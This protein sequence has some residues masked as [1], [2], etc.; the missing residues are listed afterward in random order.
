MLIFYSLRWKQL[1][2]TQNNSLQFNKEKP[3][4]QNYVKI[5]TKR[6]GGTEVFR[7]QVAQSGVT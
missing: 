5:L 7:P 6:Q 3:V 1:K 2:K 4:M